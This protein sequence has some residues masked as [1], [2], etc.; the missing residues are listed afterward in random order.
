MNDIEMI[1]VWR[2]DRIEC[3]H[4]GH[5]VVCDARGEIRHQWG[6]PTTVIYPRSSAKMIQALPLILSGAAKSHGLTTAQL[7]LACSSHIAAHYHVDPVQDWLATLGKSDSDFRCGEEEP[8]D[9]SVR[10]AMIKADKTPCRAHNN[11]SGKHCGFLTLAN[12]LGAGPDYVDPAHPVQVMIK[13]V[14]EAL[15]D[16]TSPGFGIDGCSAP[17]HA[18]TVH[19]LARA[20][21]QFASV[22]RCQTAEADAQSQLTQAMMAHPELISGNGTAC[23]ELMRACA[24]KAAIKT[25]ADGV[26]VAILPEHQLGVA[27]K[28]TDGAKRASVPA[29][30]AILHRLG[31]LEMEHPALKA[32]MTP[33]IRNFAGLITGRITPK[34]ALLDR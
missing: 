3:I 6:D 25:G 24:G 1:E 4:R 13:D 2:G 12:H 31:I 9:V 5:A 34:T 33:D 14:F 29:L 28:I 10:N 11:C 19:G 22:G 7:A 32:F 26:Y 18:C 15:T 17:N 23:T 16:E 30:A 27:V 8:R 20:M 21:A